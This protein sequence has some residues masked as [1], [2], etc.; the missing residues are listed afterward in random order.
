MPVQRDARRVDAEAWEA[1]RNELVRFVAR[2]VEPRD[3]AEDLVHSALAT[4]YARRSQ[5]DAPEKLRAWLFRI[6]RN[7]VVDH[8]RTR[9]MLER[10]PED[11]RDE[12][13][14][15]GAA[16]Q[17]LARC[18]TPLVRT[19]PPHYREIVE[20]TEI[21]GMTQAQAAA[22]LGLSVSGAKTRVQRARWLLKEKLLACCHVE[23]DSRGG[24]AGY[25]P[26]HPC[27]S[28]SPPDA[29]PAGTP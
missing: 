18:L 16:G 14:A 8:Y 20:R 5:L 3:L 25:E 29:I 28:C 1:Y 26:R 6:T 12:P 4:A 10:L 27:A 9:R 24:V 2:R 21:G 7:A 13:A 17:A 22:A 15:G 19:L 11:F 23:L